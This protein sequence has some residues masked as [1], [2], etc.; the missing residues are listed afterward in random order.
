MMN[1]SSLH[2]EGQEGQFR[3]R[4]IAHA[5][6]QK[7]IAFKHQGTNEELYHIYH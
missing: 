7:Y 2:G 6:D 1:R 5:V 4:K 3:W